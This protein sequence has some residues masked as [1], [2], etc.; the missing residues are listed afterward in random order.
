MPSSLSNYF[1]PSNGGH[2]QD[3]PAYYFNP[4]TTR[5]GIVTRIGDWF[6]RRAAVS[7]LASLTDHELAD[8]G[9]SRGDIAVAF[10]QGFV[11]NRNASRFGTKLQTGRIQHA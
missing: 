10:D 5:P 2:R 11:S 6:K 7:E 1:T 8:I 4:K 9:L 3:Y